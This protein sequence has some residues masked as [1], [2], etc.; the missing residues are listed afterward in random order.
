MAGKTYKLLRSRGLARGPHA[1]KLFGPG[2]AVEV[3][4]SV[5][6]SLGLTA[7]EDSDDG[8]AVAT[9]GTDTE[10][11]DGATVY[12]DGSGSGEPT[13][14]F[15]TDR[16]GVEAL[17]KDELEAEA[18]ARNLAIQGTG[19]RGNVVKD[20]LVSALLASD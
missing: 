6:V 15:P 10:P 18:E 20:D 1:G 17:T 14:G 4:E 13:E 16:E 12:G 5:A 2:D 9:K 8:D 7:N 3:P 11:D 19:A